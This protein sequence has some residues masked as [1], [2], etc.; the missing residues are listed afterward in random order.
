MRQALGRYGRSPCG[1]KPASRLAMVWFLRKWVRDQPGVGLASG[2][3]YRMFRFYKDNRRFNRAPSIRFLNTV[4]TVLQKQK[5]KAHALLPVVSGAY[6]CH[7]KTSGHPTLTPAAPQRC[8]A[9]GHPARSSSFSPTAPRAG[10]P[11]SSCSCSQLLQRHSPVWSMIETCECGISRL[12][13]SQ[14]ESSSS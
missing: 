2:F 1:S 13:L 7:P 11:Y 3:L 5:F 6:Y 12:F 14:K 9:S 4:F 8:F 10:H